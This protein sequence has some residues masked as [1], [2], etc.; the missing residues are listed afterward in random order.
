MFCSAGW[1]MTWRVERSGGNANHKRRV[2]FYGEEAKARDGW[3]IHL[4]PRQ[5]GVDLIDPDGRVV[6]RS[7][8]PE[9][10]NK[11]GLRRERRCQGICHKTFSI[12]SLSYI[13]WL[14]AVGVTPM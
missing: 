8:R 11:T 9:S 12:R 14:T 4:D 1:A 6:E 3:K 10:A 2:V 13:S 7:S 5:G